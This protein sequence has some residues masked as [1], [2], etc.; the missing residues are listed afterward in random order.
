MNKPIAYKSILNKPLLNALVLLAMIS[1]FSSVEATPAAYV[2]RNAY[3]QFGYQF[4]SGSLFGAI[5]AEIPLGEGL[6][7]DVGLGLELNY[8]GS[9]GA[10]VSAKGLIFPSLF[11]EPPIALALGTDISL[12]DAQPGLGIRARLGA[13]GSF[14]FSPF[15][16]TLA[17]YFAFGSGGAS[18]DADLNARYYF[19]PF[20]LEVNANYSTL[21]VF[22]G[23]LGLR[24][25]F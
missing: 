18:F 4:G 25:L 16:L 7:V 24:F 15:V 12:F 19:D 23:T 9:L 21:G 11:G 2:E 3:A 5:G 8:R 22:S 13:I 17:P 20:A 14:D 1:S 6:P 10:T